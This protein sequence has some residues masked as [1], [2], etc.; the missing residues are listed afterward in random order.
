MANLK[1]FS[2]HNSASKSSSSKSSLPFFVFSHL[3]QTYF[4]T[5]DFAS[6]TTEHTSEQARNRRHVNIKDTRKVFTHFD[7]Q[8]ATEHLD[9]QKT[10]GGHLSTRALKA[11]KNSDT[12]GTQALGLLR[13]LGTWKLKYLGTQAFGH[14]R[15]YNKQTKLLQDVLKM[16]LVKSDAFSVRLIFPQTSIHV[17]IDQF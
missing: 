14:S 12:L 9:T 6:T 4:S 2:N 15:Q 10:L 16:Q 11:L 17:Q 7:S 13:H 3:K 1:S 8:R 5:W